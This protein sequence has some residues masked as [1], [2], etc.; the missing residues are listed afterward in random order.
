MS[1]EKLQ[2][3]LDGEVGRIRLTNPEKHNAFDDGL[4]A[5]LTE[6]FAAMGAE[7]G[8]RVVVME[9][10][11]KSF[12]AGADLNWMKRVA[13]YSFEENVRDAGALAEMLKVI[14]FLPKPVVGKI[15]GAAFGG[16]VGLVSC[17]DIAV[18]SERAS[19]CL[20]EVKLGLIPSAISPY[21]V[22]AIGGRAA[23][24]YFQTAERF[25]AQTAL[26]LGLL[27][28]VVAEESLDETVEDIVSALL[29]CGPVAT[30]E[31]KD[32]A[33]AV[34]GP[35]TEEVIE[36]TVH[37]IARLRA[38]EEAREGMSAFLEKRSASWNTHR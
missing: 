2:V 34:D 26:R 10:E 33:F 16:G 19:F 12:S 27:H 14:N 36:D 1:D 4:I 22:A 11:G 23:R 8:V 25:D 35:I 30:A 32:L 7:T 5:D 21:V 15:Q 31:A 20:S 38:T 9:S 24:R 13:E 6:A 28:D 3:S 37:R 29:A 18:G 17:C